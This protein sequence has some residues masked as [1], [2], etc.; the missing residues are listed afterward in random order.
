MKLE[1]IAQTANVRTVRH[2]ERQALLPSVRQTSD[3]RPH[4]GSDIAPLRFR[5]RAK[6]AGR[7]QAVTSGKIAGVE[8]TLAGPTR[9]LDHLRVEPRTWRSTTEPRQILNAL[10][11]ER[12]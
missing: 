12:A 9:I 3:N 8:A 10:H 1:R 11:E 7:L 4:V 5:R 6:P 2:H